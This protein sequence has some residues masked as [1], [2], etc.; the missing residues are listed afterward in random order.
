MNIFPDPFHFERALND[1]QLLFLTPS[2]DSMSLTATHKMGIAAI[3]MAGS[4]FLSRLMGLIRD[5]VVSWQFGAGSESDV[6][7]A[8]FV[9]PDFINH[10]LA[11]GYISITLIPLLSKCFAEDEENGWRFFSAVFWWASLSISLFTAVAWFLA[12]ELARLVGPGFSPEKQA[13]LAFFLRIIL[14]AQ[15]FFLPG[16]CIS[17]LLYI[18]RQFF[19]PAL[20]PLVYNGCII[21]GGLLVSGKGMEGFCW[22]VLAGAATGAFLLPAWAARA[23]TQNH[24]GEG[25]PGGLTF[26]AV[27]RH[28]MLKRLLFLA[29]PLMLGLSIV[30]LDEQ[31]VRIFGSLAGEGAVSLLSY[32]RRIMQVPVGVVAQAAGVA[33]FPFLAALAAKNDTTGFDRTLNTALQGSLL[34]VLPLTACMMALALPTLGFL[35]EGGRFSA[36]ETVAAT[37]LLQLLLLSVPFWV[38]QQV[39]GR[40]FYARQ[41]TLTP[42]LT[43]TLATFAALPV[44]PLAVHRWG[45]TGVALLT[46]VSLLVYTAA[47]TLAWQRK[48]GSE[49][50][51]GTWLLSLKSLLLCLPATL[52]ALYVVDRLPNVLIN[53]FPDSMA[54]LPPA[55]LH[56]LVLAVAGS[57]FLL[58]YGIPA[59]LWLPELL[60]FRRSTSKS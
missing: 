32:A 15:I 44:Y 17:A 54:L 3:I 19:A 7:F 9:V 38:I 34:V 24:L 2:G 8:A 56:A 14:P 5:K 18:R 21:A 45:A 25:V 13:R 40:A 11:G 16:A 27:L 6:Y 52:L 36:E 10:L 58:A 1:V 4:V 53:F 28:P 49:A 29:L 39:L 60:H 51:L 20:T 23:G 42:A 37:P 12:P 57:V 33:S 41:D 46:T 48:Q 22:G 50:F 59:R 47:L 55:L 43:G 26:R 35:F 31:F 30:V